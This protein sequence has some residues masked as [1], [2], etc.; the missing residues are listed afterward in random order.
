[1]VSERGEGTWKLADDA[2]VRFPGTHVFATSDLANFLP[3]QIDSDGRPTFLAESGAILAA[4]PGGGPTFAND[5]QGLHF[6]NLAAYT[7][8]N[9]PYGN[10]PTNKWQQ[11]IVAQMPE[12]LVIKPPQPIT[13]SNYKTESPTLSVVLGQ[14][15]YAAS[16]PRFNGAVVTITGA[17]SS[18]LSA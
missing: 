6:G 5:W 16:G 15:L 1:V 10:A 3:S 9:L 12:S 14:R 17:G 18:G 4:E 2:G 11:A 13:F 8:K 7:D